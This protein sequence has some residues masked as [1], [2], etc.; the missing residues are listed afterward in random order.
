[1]DRVSDSRERIGAEPAEPAVGGAQPSAEGD[2]PT[3][4]GSEAERIVRRAGPMRAIGRA[5][6]ALV[7][8][9]ALVGAGWYGWRFWQIREVRQAPMVSLAEARVRIGNDE[10]G[11]SWNEA[12]VEER[13]AHELLVRP[14]SLDVTE[15]TVAAYGVCVQSGACVE[16]AKGTHCTW[17][18]PDMERH[19]INCVSHEEAEAFCKWAGKRLPTEVE[20]E[21]AAGGI[22]PKRLFPWGDELPDAGRANVCGWEC[23]HGAAPTR[24]LRGIF[25]FSDGAEG[26]APVGSYPAGDT[27][28]RVKDLA[29]NVWEWTASASCAYPDHD[30]PPGEHRIIRGGG[31]THRYLLSPEVTTREELVRTARSEG[32]GFRCAR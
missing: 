30:C 21:Y 22:N 29:G 11:R 16:P 23:S 15:I 25:E 14:F 3:S 5:G 2:G 31:W 24:R 17:E 1:V 32:V 6:T 27:P 26:T 8:V 12:E 18:R 4:A 13:P 7:V 10:R 19:P 20:W 9:A 28:E